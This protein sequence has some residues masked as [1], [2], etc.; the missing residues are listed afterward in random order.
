MESGP[1]GPVVPAGPTF[2]GTVSVP[3][4][5]VLSGD[6]MLGA[7]GNRIDTHGQNLSRLGYHMKQ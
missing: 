5:P 6:G 1:V 2:D 3:S 4:T 7:A